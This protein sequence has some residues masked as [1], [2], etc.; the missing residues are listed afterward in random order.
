M[1][2]SYHSITVPVNPHICVFF[3]VPGVYELLSG[4]QVPLRGRYNVP[5]AI[6]N[7]PPAAFPRKATLATKTPNAQP[8]KG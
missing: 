6:R 4:T 2:K 7:R 8:I 5:F 1:K 3:S